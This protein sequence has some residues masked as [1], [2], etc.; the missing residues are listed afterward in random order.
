MSNEQVEHAA[1]THCYAVC[2][3]EQSCWETGVIYFARGERA[4]VIACGKESLLL[5]HQSGR[6]FSVWKHHV[7]VTSG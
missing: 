3:C 1:A 4:E 2:I 7:E 6:R 5:R